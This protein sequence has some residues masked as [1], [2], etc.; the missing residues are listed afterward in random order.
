MPE[1]RPA[2]RRLLIGSGLAVVA[3]VVAV[4]LI[5]AGQR[6][7]GPGRDSAAVPASG[8]LASPAAA[9]PGAESAGPSGSSTPA[10]GTPSA[11]PGGGSGALVP[12]VS[13]APTTAHG[14]I[15]TYDLPAPWR[16]GRTTTIR[17]AVYEPAG[18]DPSG[19]TRYPVLYETPY[20]AATWTQPQRFDL[21][22]A[23]DELIAQRLVPPELIL[24]IGL[25]GGPYLDSECADSLDGRAHIESWLVDTLVPWVD[26]HFPT[27]ASRFG[28]ATIGA[29]QGGYCAASLWSHHPDVFGAAVVESGY[30]VSG[31]HSTQTPDAWRPFGGN[32]AYEASQSPITRVPTIPAKLASGSLVLLEADPANWFYGPQL[33]KFQPVL[34]SSGV[35]Y[36][37]Y[38]DPGGHS[39]P[40]FARETPR[41]LVDLARW[42]AAHGVS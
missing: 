20:G 13:L 29:S 41:M 37:V 16:E 7:G 1:R 32:T 28:R 33:A 6:L 9:A 25:S 23:M 10:R 21:A 11:M 5:A 22:G 34:Q 31:L 3:I 19:R 26:G 40:A 36:R 39:W 17:I 8:A 42:M 2:R 18:F 4:A 30:F 15:V 38:A 27:V 12:A 14:R 24:F 35:P